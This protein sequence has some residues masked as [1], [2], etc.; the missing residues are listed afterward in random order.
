MNLKLMAGGF[1]AWLTTTKRAYTPFVVSVISWPFVAVA[2]NS[3]RHDDGMTAGLFCFL[4]AGLIQSF[5]LDLAT[6]DGRSKEATYW[7]GLIRSMLSSGGTVKI[8]VQHTFQ[9]RDH[10]VWQS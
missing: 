7:M 9:G 6:T 3:L 2:F 1:I 4:A 8:N 5:A 10:D